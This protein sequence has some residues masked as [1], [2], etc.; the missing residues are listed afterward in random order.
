MKALA[1]MLNEI[2]YA[3]DVKACDV[4][5]DSC[6]AVLRTPEGQQL[7]RVLWDLCKPA[8]NPFLLTQDN[9]EAACNARVGELLM[10][11]FSHNPNP[12]IPSHGQTNKR[13]SRRTKSS[14]I[15]E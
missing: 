5:E 6:T 3:N 13:G 14:G 10:M 12:T 4:F 15:I 9:Q 7:Q 1:D 11:I 8:Q 2:V